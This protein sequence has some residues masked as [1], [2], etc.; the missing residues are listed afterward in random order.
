MSYGTVLVLLPF[1][2]VALLDIK[3][4]IQYLSSKRPK[5]VGDVPPVSIIV[6]TYN[7][8]GT[9]SD[10]LS[11]IFNSDLPQCEVI[12]VDDGSEDGTL[13][14]C[15]GFSD[16]RLIIV[17]E[18]H[19]GKWSAL[20]RGVGIARHDAI[21][22][23]DAD[24]T[25]ERNSIKV[26]LSRLGDC[27]AVA[28]N[29]IIAN[30]S[31]PF[32]HLQAQEHLRISMHRRATGNITTVSGPFACFRRE[33]LLRHPFRR[34]VVEDFEHTARIRRDGARICYEPGSRAHTRMP[35]GLRGYLSQRARWSSGTLKE[36]EM[37]GI[38][39][40]GLAWGYLISA[41]DIA[42]LLFAIV[43]G[44]YQALLAIVLFEGLVQ[45][46]GNAR[47]GTGMPI[48]SLLF[49]PYLVVLATMHLA[50]SFYSIFI[51]IENV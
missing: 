44:Y 26:L 7:A 31:L 34:S 39:F 9:I 21:V 38:P 24:T 12:M 51:G 8:E 2:I 16:P 43:F 33:T 42:T 50:I 5:R 3:L 17:H 41:L 47:E 4:L 36:M 14:V 40:R 11:S 23:I 32:A 45:T 27:D 20:N 1:V 18:D 49:Y 30:R 22:T 10:T 15:R 13:N 46:M 25:V 37:K 6:P 35:S 29:L 19:I 28:G 48:G